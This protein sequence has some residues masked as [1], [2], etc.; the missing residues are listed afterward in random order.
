MKLNWR[1][2]LIHFIAAWFFMYSFHTLA[3][4]H[5][6]NLIDILRHSDK[7][8]LTNALSKNQVSSIEVSYFVVWTSIGNTL[9]FLVAFIISLII[10][11]KRKWFWF[12][13]IIVFVLVC[14]LSRFELL[15]WDFLKNIFL[16]PGEIFGNIT[17]EYLTNGIILLTLGLLTFFLSK[18][19]KFIALGNTSPV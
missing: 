18:T 15:G 9:G 4:L 1:Q 8:D 2:V 12:N 7:G 11:I 5:N 14:I 10:S 16:T 19:T 13:S 6:T 3:V 17:L